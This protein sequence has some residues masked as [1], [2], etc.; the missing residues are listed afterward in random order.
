MKI[1]SAKLLF[2]VWFC[3]W[4]FFSCSWGLLLFL[5]SQYFVT[6]VVFNIPASFVWKAF[7]VIC[8]ACSSGGFPLIW[9]SYFYSNGLVEQCKEKKI[10]ALIS[11]A[12]HKIFIS[13][14]FIVITLQY[15][16][17]LLVDMWKYF[18]LWFKA[19]ALLMSVLTDRLLHE[20]K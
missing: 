15:T 18:I 19:T 16:D 12:C 5:L 11:L 1:E 4:D 3:C 10:R 13:F 14:T 17:M 7:S 9:S 8:N 20:Y 6:I 2:C